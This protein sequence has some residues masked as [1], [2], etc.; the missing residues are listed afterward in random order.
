MSLEGL[1][2]QPW[3]ATGCSGV[4]NKVAGKCTTF[5]HEAEGPACMVGDVVMAFFCPAAIVRAMFSFSLVGSE[6]ERKY[7]ALQGDQVQV[8]SLCL[9][10]AGLCA[11]NQK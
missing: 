7:Q 8:F 6:C 11:V 5:C 1:G 4:Q 9:N 10:I 2:P 3:E